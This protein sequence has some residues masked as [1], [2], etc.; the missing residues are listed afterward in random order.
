MTTSHTDVLSTLRR[1]YDAF[2]ETYV[3]TWSTLEGYSSIVEEFLRR[4]ATPGSSVLDVGCGPGHLTAS[5]PETVRVTGLDLA[6]KMIDVARKARPH[7]EYHVHDYYDPFPTSG[8]FD[9]I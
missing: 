8:P 2:S 6:P 9:V 3:G 1:R 7:G 4:V 5:V